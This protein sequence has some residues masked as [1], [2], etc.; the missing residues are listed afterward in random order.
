MQTNARTASLPTADIYCV[1]TTTLL[2]IALIAI[3]RPSYLKTPNFYPDPR[4]NG[5]RRKKGRRR[6]KY[7][8]VERGQTVLTDLIA[9]IESQK[10]SDGEEDSD[11]TP[12]HPILEDTANKFV[13]VNP[14]IPRTTARNLVKEKLEQSAEIL[15]LFHQI[16]EASSKVNPERRKRPKLTCP[17][18][19]QSERVQR[20]G[21]ATD[22]Q[23]K[24][25]CKNHHDS[26]VKRKS[27]GYVYFRD[28]SSLEG[29]QCTQL[30]LKDVARHLLFSTAS[31]SEISDLLKVS[32]YLVEFTASM[33]STNLRRFIS[34]IIPSTK[35][36]ALFAFDCAGTGFRA[37]FGLA[38]GDLEGQPIVFSWKGSEGEAFR[39][40]IRFLKEE[41]LY[42]SSRRDQCSIFLVDGAKEFLKV[43]A[44]E[45]PGAILVRQ[46][47]SERG[48][49][50][51]LCHWF[52]KGKEYSCQI[53]WNLLLHEGKASRRTQNKREVR[54][55]KNRQPRASRSIPKEVRIWKYRQTMFYLPRPRK[56][57]DARRNNPESEDP[58]STQAN[59]VQEGEK[60]PTDRCT[61][62]E[63]KAG[64]PAKLIFVGSPSEARKL[65]PF[66]FLY[67]KLRARFAGIYI[68]SN[69]V[70]GEISEFKRL[71][72]KSR[73]P[74]S[75]ETLFNLLRARFYIRKQKMTVEEV[76][77]ILDEIFTIEAIN[78]HMVIR[79]KRSGAGGTRRGGI[80]EAFVSAIQ[81]GDAVEICYTDN[82]GM[83]M[84]R[85]VEP[86]D[87][88]VMNGS[89]YLDAF[90]RLRQDNRTFKLLWIDSVI[91]TELLSEFRSCKYTKGLLESYERAINRHQFC[92]DRGLDRAKVHQAWVRYRERKDLMASLMNVEVKRTKRGKVRWTNTLIEAVIKAPDLKAF[93][94]VKGISFRIAMKKK[95][96]RHI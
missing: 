14:L 33:I 12:L 72:T 46:F 56:S 67:K 1:S 91:P 61:K 94:K 58:S 10:V 42:Q 39:Q 47:H 53:P 7:K 87:I 85:I 66:K 81:Y 5:P 38:M 23:Q 34:R 45:I 79:E 54:Q 4:G 26:G 25:V 55:R 68:T 19:H 80:V 32:R 22:G 84:P 69:I 59:S 44:E 2:L 93:C 29:L 15:A 13:R 70:E 60:N 31:Y 21:R 18:C 11:D 48:R 76:E 43:W 16:E 82:E 90:C 30:L 63:P 40:Y 51:V 36:V 27:A 3:L 73:S 88:R 77:A 64:P 28:H 71:N 62:G 17:V 78:R 8:P 74:N 20:N 75:G 52:Y 65:A 41:G 57:R 9:E 96:L 50:L 35:K 24:W 37:S 89:L 86:L 95:G 49:G 83:K 92:E 6:R